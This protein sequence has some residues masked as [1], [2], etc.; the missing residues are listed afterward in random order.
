MFASELTREPYVSVV[1]PCYNESAHLYNSLNSISKFLQGLSK[2]YE[3]IVSDDGSTDDTSG[4]DWRQFKDHF[5]AQYIRS[6]T[7]NGK[8][9]ALRHGLKMGKGRYIFFTDADLPVDLEAIKES[10][11]FLEER[12]FEIVIGDRRLPESQVIGSS[13][14]SRRVASKIFNWGVQLLVLPGITDSQCCMKGFENKA[15]NKLLRHSSLDSYA[16][17][18]ELLYLAKLYH[19]RIKRIPVVWKDLRAV[20]P[21]KKLIRM[22][23]TSLLDVV[24]MRLNHKRL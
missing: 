16:F 10:I 5:N 15:L 4:L 18:V 9:A 20:L 11:K 14:T 7:R 22:L 24:I 2:S 13:A 8:G 23:T 17:D 1:I 19:L 6:D 3:I 12:K 21:L